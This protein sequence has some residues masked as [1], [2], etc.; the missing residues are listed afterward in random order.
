MARALL[1]YVQPNC[2]ELGT[3]VFTDKPKIP[4]LFTDK[5]QIR[6]SLFSASCLLITLSKNLQRLLKLLYFFAVSTLPASH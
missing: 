1:T 3:E 4:L 6:E 5:R 2:H